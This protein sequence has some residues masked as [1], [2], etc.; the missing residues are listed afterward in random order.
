M[1]TFN[2]AGITKAGS[3]YFNS[4]GVWPYIYS[5]QISGNI[6]YNNSYTSASLKLAAVGPIGTA[7]SD[8]TE[9]STVLFAAEPTDLYL[10]VRADYQLLG[11]F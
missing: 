11:I 2:Y 4:G 7:S 9:W 5:T 3:K 6:S 8:E 1:Q 10:S